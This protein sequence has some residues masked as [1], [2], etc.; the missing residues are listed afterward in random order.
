MEA[1]E[2][3]IEGQSL[4]KNEKEPL[5]KEEGME[6]AHCYEDRMCLWEEGE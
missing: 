3:R 4:R 6:M 5:A 1:R 2:I